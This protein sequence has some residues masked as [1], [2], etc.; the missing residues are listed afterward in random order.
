M[1][2]EKREEGEAFPSENNYSSHLV[3]NLS[4]ES[5]PRMA[6][7]FWEQEKIC[8][9]YSSDPIICPFYALRIYIKSKE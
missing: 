6:K 4:W 5:G 9:L 8:F 7:T 2:Q 1:D 3:S